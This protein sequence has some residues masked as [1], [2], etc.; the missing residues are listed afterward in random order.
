MNSTD[1]LSIAATFFLYTIRFFTYIQHFPHCSSIISNHILCAESISPLRA[2]HNTGLINDILKR[3][4]RKLFLQKR[5]PS[6]QD[7]KSLRSHSYAGTGNPCLDRLI[8]ISGMRFRAKSRRI[9][10]ETNPFFLSPTFHESGS[11]DAHST[12]GCVKN[13]TLNSSEFAML[14]LSAFMSRSSTSHE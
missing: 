5:M 12:M 10:F 8:I 13:G 2:L 14:I 4:L 9:R 1:Q 3:E 6:A 11:F 7:P